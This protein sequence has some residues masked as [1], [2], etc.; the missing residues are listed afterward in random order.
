M[1][2]WFVGA[3]YLGRSGVL[4]YWP[5]PALQLVLVSLTLLLLV[6]YA[7]IAWFRSAVR[8][9]PMQVLVAL[10]ISRFVGFYFLALHEEGKLPWAFAVPGGWGDIVVA[11]LALAVIVIPL[12]TRWGRT[13]LAAW[14]TFG[15][16]DLLLVVG[17]AALLAMREPMSMLALARIPL[18]LLPTFLVP[19]LLASHLVIFDRLALMSRPSA[20][21]PA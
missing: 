14:N 18:C 9:W 1:C 12:E 11:G 20:P 3:A 19:I 7:R 4:F 6:A 2:A 16:I 15:L 10:H 8:G 5:R 21:R 13:A 17:T